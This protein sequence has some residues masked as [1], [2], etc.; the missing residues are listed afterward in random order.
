[1]SCSDEDDEKDIY[2]EARHI[3]VSKGYQY[4]NRRGRSNNGGRVNSKQSLFR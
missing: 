3:K 1:M 4:E 2:S